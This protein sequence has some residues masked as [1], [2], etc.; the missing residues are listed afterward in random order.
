M[1]ENLKTDWDICFNNGSDGFHIMLNSST[2][3]KITLLQNEN[4]ENV[5]SIDDSTIWKWDNPNGLLESTAVGDYRNTNNIYILDRGYD[6]SNVFQGYKK[7]IVDSVTTTHYIITYA[8]LNNSETIT[9]KI[10]KNS[11]TNNIRYSFNTNS[12]CNNQPNKENWDLLFT[13]Y[14]HLFPNDTNTPAYLVTG[15]LINPFQTKVAIDTMQ[16]FND[17]NY[18]MIGQYSF[19]SH[20]DIIGYNW[21]D[22]DLEN[23]VYSINTNLNYIIKSSENRYFKLHFIDFYNS[24]GEK[25]YPK[26]EME[27]LF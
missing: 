3:S 22:Y 5:T 11:N 23:Q 21:K 20:Q 2:F 1:N 7:F 13:Q 19:S 12:I 14:T 18:D 15:V 6:I 26:F 9:K 27:E 25:G 17:I 24:N 16:N 4:F 8:N 10:M